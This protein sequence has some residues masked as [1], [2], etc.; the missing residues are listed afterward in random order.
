LRRIVP[1]LATLDLDRID[2]TVDEATNVLIVR[3]WVGGQRA[4]VLFNFSHE[5]QRVAGSPSP[6]PPGAGGEQRHGTQPAPSATNAEGESPLPAREGDGG[7][8]RHRWAKALDSAS[9]GY[10]GPGSMIPDILT[11]GTN[12]FVALQPQSVVLFT[13]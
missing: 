3:R 12:T 10:L 13:G 8:A 4:L 11:P 2:V 5:E 6:V 1:A 7:W 9:T